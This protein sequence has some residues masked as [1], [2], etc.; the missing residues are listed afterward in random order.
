MNRRGFLASLAVAPV[1]ITSIRP[2]PKR[3]E[4]LLGWAYAAASTHYSGQTLMLVG[5]TGHDVKAG[6]TLWMRWADWNKLSFQARQATLSDV[7]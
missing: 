6:E 2:E 3:P 1:A 4:P 5:V 7:R